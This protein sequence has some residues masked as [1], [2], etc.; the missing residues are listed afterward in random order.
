[1]LTISNPILPSSVT[2]AMSQELLAR[3]S[4][5][6]DPRRE[7]CRLY[8]LSHLLFLSTV[9]VLAGCNT[10]VEVESFGKARRE[11]FKSLGIFSNKMPSHDTIGRI[12][13]L[14]EPRCF[15]E[16]F[17]EW[18]SKIIGPVSGVIAI[19]GKTSRGSRDGEN[20]IPLHTVSVYSSDAGV[21]LAH[22]DVGEKSNEIPAIPEVIKSLEIAGSMVTIDAMGCQ[23]D[24]VAA[25]RKKKADYLLA[26]KDNQPT[27]HDA[28][29]EQF[30]NCTT[31]KWKRN[32]EHTFSTTQDEGH[33]RVEFREAW[34]CPAKGM[35]FDDG[36]W[37]DVAQVVCNRSTRIVNGE[38]TIEDR[39]FITSSKRPAS[40]ILRSIREH[41]G[42][43]NKVHWILDVA[44]AEDKCTIRKDHAP[45]NISTIRRWVLNMLRVQPSKQ[46]MNIRRKMAGWSIP[47][48]ES[49]LLGIRG[50]N[51]E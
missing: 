32:N 47:F 41:W 19:D 1:M 18:V 10:C 29:I 11:W 23:T 39:H 5:L 24:I 36:K 14:L 31:D 27:L 44:F 46:S 4:S 17:S 38:I 21:T 6:P 51:R 8:Q 9:A 43:E 16:I 35:A 33:G 48:L 20:G 13:R 42:I 28:I 34:C 12:L 26:V 22:I 49:L 50:I 30:I 37:I 45:K 2:V 3:F 7:H 40:K 15:Q 25:I